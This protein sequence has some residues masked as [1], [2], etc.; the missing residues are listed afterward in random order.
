[1]DANR[2]V[3]MANQIAQ[4][5]AS[6]GAGA[7]AAIADHIAKNWDPRMRAA[8]LAHVAAGGAGLSD[9]AKTALGRLSA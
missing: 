8:I 7:E 4:F 3:T 1:M 9:V 2:L 5:F 6:Q